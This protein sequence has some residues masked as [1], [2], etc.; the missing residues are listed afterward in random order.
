MN[1]CFHKIALHKRAVSCLLIPAFLLLALFPFHYHLHHVA[2]ATDH[3]PDVLGHV[4]DMHVLTDIAGSSH[5]KDSHTIDPTSHATFSMAGLQLPLFILA[6]ALLALSLPD[7]G[8]ICYRLQSVI[9][10]FS[11]P[12]R[13]STPP[14]RAPPHA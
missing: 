4:T 11:S 1:S 8:Q 12:S 13:Y 14:L 2:V 3:G 7:A 5:H 9:C 6:F 10:R